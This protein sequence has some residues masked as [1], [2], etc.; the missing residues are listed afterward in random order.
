MVK[1]VRGFY[2]L[3]K[4]MGSQKDDFLLS[5]FKKILGKKPNASYSNLDEKFTP[6]FE[7]F[8]KRYQ[9]IMKVTG[10]NIPPHKWSYHRIGLVTKGKASYMCGMYQFTAKKN[11]LLIIPARMITAS[12]WSPDGSGY[13]ALFNSELLVQNNLSHKLFENKG[14]LQINVHP[15]LFLAAGESKKVEGIFKAILKE[16]ESCEPFKNELIA[17]KIV[18]LL[19][20]CERYYTKEN[21]VIHNSKAGDLHRKFAEL[22]EQRFSEER[23]VS[24]YAAKLFVHPNYLNAVIKS[25]TGFTAKESIQNRI[26]LESKYLLHTTNLSVKEISSKIG[27][28]DPNYFTTF[29][30]R[31]ENRSPLSYRASFI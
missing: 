16:Q 5:E 25:N 18:E 2:Y 23:T 29:F 8:V 20:L 24:F 3:V 31:L 21:S 22:L 7:L 10:T 11:T 12:E 9:D 19:I 27:F 26:I 15:Y 28:D 1:Q 30:T 4:T 13:T 6:K 14:I 17:I